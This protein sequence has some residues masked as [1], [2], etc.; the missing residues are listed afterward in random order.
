MD[1]QQKK[2][3][4]DK[5]PQSVWATNFFKNFP[6]NILLKDI[7]LLHQYQYFAQKYFLLFCIHSEEFYILY[8]AET[9]GK[10]CTLYIAQ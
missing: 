1:I 6:K 2:K 7:I 9:Y 8:R 4:Q 3:L 5:M 10:P